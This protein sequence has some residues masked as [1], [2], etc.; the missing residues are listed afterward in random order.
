MVG[1][2]VHASGEVWSATNADIRAAL[3][4]RYGAGDAALQKSCANGQTPVTACPGN[5][6]WIQIV[7]DSFLLMANSRVSMV[8]ARD[9]MLAADQVRFGGANQDLLW[10]A[11]AARGL[12]EAAASNGNGDVDPTPGFTSP[13]ADEATLTFKPE[14]DDAPVRCS[15]LWSPPPWSGRPW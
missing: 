13:Y 12:G 6:R 3:V 5:R 15:P 2:Q 9:V 8:D 14:G 11:F 1:L 7:F 10:N 4:G